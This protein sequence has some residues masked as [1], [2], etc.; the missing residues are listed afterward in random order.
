MWAEFVD[1]WDSITNMDDWET[2]KD[3]LEYGAQDSSE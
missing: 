1:A 3:G 2:K